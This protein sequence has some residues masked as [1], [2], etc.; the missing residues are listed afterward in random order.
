MPKKN[1]NMK[2]HIDNVNKPCKQ[3]KCEW[4]I[5]CSE[6]YNCFNVYKYFITKPHTLQE[7]A[8]ILMISHTTTKQIQELAFQKIKNKIK[9]KDL[10]DIQ[11]E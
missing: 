9:L 3:K 1:K 8:D 4:W 7:V 10:E 6:Y 2:C 5:K 11:D